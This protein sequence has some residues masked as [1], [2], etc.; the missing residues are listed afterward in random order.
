ML[1]RLGNPFDDRLDFRSEASGKFRI[2]GALPIARFD[3]FRTRSRTK[4]DR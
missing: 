3:Q 4:D 2:A 1:W